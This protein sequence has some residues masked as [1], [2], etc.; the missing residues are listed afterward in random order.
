MERV[1]E[2]NNVP[3]NCNVKIEAIKL[4]RHVLK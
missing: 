1:F 2:Y 3:D 4:K